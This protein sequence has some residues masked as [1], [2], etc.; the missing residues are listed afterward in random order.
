MALA[1]ALGRLMASRT[2]ARDLLPGASLYHP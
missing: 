1:R 2:A